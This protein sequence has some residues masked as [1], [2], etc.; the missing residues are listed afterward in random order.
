MGV[1]RAKHKLREDR[2]MQIQETVDLSPHLS[3]CL[4]LKT[5]LLEHGHTHLV[6]LAEAVLVLHCQNGVTVTEKICPKP[7]IFII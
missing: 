7:K 3:F 4:L 5:E 2:I 1:F 6:T